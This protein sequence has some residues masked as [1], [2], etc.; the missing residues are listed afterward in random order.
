MDEYRIN[1]ITALEKVL[2]DKNNVILFEKYIW[3]CYKDNP[4]D[5]TNCVYQVIGDILKKEKS[6]QNIFD[7]L[8][9]KQFNWEHYSFETEK[10]KLNEQDDFI[11][12]PFEVEEGVLEC[13]CGSKRVFSYSKQ[14]RS[15]DEPMTTYA[16]CV[17]CGSTWQYSG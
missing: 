15:S 14:T 1:G 12:N 2:K 17:K 4:D 13:K 9:K 7:S 16:E 10:N 6:I 5:Y 11:E 3:L 8:K